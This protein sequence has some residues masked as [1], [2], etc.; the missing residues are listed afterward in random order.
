MIVAACS[1][2]RARRVQHARPAAHG[3]QQRAAGQRSRHRPR[4][5]WTSRSKPGDDFYAYANGAWV[6][7]TE[8]PADRS[9]IGGFCIADQ[10]REKNT[11]E[12]FDDILKANADR[13]QRRADRQLLQRLSRHRRDRPA[14][15]WRRPRPT[16]TR[17]RAIADKSAAERGDRQ[18]APRRHRSAQRDQFPDRES[19]RHVRHAGARRRRASNCPI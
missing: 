2:A 17:S 13:R 5:G 3:A 19:V 16:S 14:R 18:H 9:S 1:L 11:R 8:I 12:L 6:K 15:A 4:R 10:V 7:T